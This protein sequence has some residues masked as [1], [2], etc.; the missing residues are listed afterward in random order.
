MSTA[1]V[2][3]VIARVFVALIAVAALFGQ[4]F[5]GQFSFPSTMTG[6]GGLITAAFGTRTDVRSPHNSA[7]LL[8]FAG[9]AFLGFLLEAYEYYSRHNV[10]GNDFAWEL[11]GPFLVS[12]IYI[13][14]SATKLSDHLFQK[15]H[16]V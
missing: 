13:A 12:L 9:I 1:Q 7:V 14:F 6:V 3:L 15:P 4:L 16:A 2:F 8:A 11:H 10:P 5:F